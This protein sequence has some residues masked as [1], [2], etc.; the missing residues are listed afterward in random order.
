MFLLK[1]IDQG[2][3]VISY[4]TIV[5]SYTHNLFSVFAMS[6]LIIPELYNKV[7]VLVDELYA[8]IPPVLELNISEQ[9]GTY[10]GEGVTVGVGVSVGVGV[11]DGVGV[12]V[13]VTAIVPVGVGVGAGPP[14]VR[15]ND[16]PKYP[17]Q[18]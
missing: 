11:I 9:V 7:L 15:T 4:S 2:L 18:L 13:G 17:P 12:L 5:V 6:P 14:I 3:N 10:I 16:C 8:Y 1:V